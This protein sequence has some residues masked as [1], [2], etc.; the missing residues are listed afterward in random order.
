M[1]AWLAPNEHDVMQ[2][3]VQTIGGHDARVV[4]ADKSRG[5]RSYGWAFDSKTILY[6]QDADGD[7]NFQMSSRS[8]SILTTSAI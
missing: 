4:T 1:L 7:E 8:I 3:W 5:I 6:Q 2:V